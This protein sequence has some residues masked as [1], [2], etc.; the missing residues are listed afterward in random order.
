MGVIKA[1][2]ANSNQLNCCR[3]KATCCGHMVMQTG[4][5]G[6]SGKP[7]EIEF[8]GADQDLKPDPAGQPEATRK[9][10]FGA[11]WRHHYRKR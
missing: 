3:S 11:D 8:A 9:S 4:R 10:A 2:A 6:F 1:I 7:L 5:C